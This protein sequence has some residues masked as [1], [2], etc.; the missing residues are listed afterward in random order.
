[1]GIF[2]FQISVSLDDYVAGPRQSEENPL[3]VGGED[4]HHEGI[5]AVL[6]QAKRAAGD[7]DVL[8]GGGASVVQQYLAA[9]LVD[10]FELHVV[11]VLLGDGERLLA[12]VGNL[13]VEEVRAIEAPGVTRRQVAGVCGGRRFADSC[14][15]LAATASTEDGAHVELLSSSVCGRECS[16]QPWFVAVSVADRSAAPLHRAGFRRTSVPSDSSL[17]KGRSQ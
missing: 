9:G 7:K 1:M 4:L 11:P 10:E 3:G 8:L 14:F 2:R 12:N 15:P 16:W 13:E 5:E 17:K 6:E